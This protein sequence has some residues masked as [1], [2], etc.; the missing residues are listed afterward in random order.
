IET[1][2]VHCDGR[3]L[4]AE[5]DE[6]A[7]VASGADADS[8]GHVPHGRREAL[9]RVIM[10]A[11]RPR[12]LP[13]P[14]L[15]VNGDGPRQPPRQVRGIGIFSITDGQ[16]IM[17]P[18]SYTSPLV[19]EVGDERSESAGGGLR[20]AI[21]DAPTRRTSS[22]RDDIRDLP[23]TRGRLLVVGC[24]SLLTRPSPRVEAE[25]AADAP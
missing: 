23:H 17:A 19:G 22:L 21:V 7:L 1:G 5:Q 16:E 25:R 11:R 3:P 20:W 15:D 9:Q 8:G 13:G 10:S 2:R 14:A 6:I 24:M 4:D 18:S 12:P